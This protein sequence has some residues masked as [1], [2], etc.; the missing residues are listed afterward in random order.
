MKQS[1]GSGTKLKK[2]IP[3]PLRVISIYTIFQKSRVFE[4][5]QEN[6]LPSS[7]DV[8]IDSI[9]IIFVYD[10]SNVCRVFVCVNNVHNLH[11]D[12]LKF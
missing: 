2:S 3:I 9:R 1:V 4:N 8:C 5:R 11:V 10:V 6:R 7:Q 12:V